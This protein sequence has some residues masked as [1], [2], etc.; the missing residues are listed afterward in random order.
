MSNNLYFAS[1][2][3]FHGGFGV[4]T[5]ARK[6][7]IRQTQRASRYPLYLPMAR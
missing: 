2:P 1:I 7:A 3:K 4:G 5:F 6:T